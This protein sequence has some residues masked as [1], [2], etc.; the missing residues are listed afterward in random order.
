MLCTVYLQI[1]NILSHISIMRLRGRGGKSVAG[2]G[3]KR[4]SFELRDSAERQCGP[5]PRPVGAPGSANPTH[6]CIQWRSGVR[7]R[8]DRTPI[9]EIPVRLVSAEQ[10]QRWSRGGGP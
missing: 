2:I 7:Y 1:G 3:R 10:D 5:V 4:A 9:V 6:S 8:S